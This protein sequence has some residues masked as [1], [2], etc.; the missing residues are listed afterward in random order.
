MNGYNQPQGNTGYPQQNYQQP[1]QYQQP[2]Q[3]QQG[4]MVQGE[5]QNPMEFTTGIYRGKIWSRTTNTGKQ[6]YKVMFSPEQAPDKQFSFK[7][8]DS[9]KGFDQMQ[10]GQLYKIG[11]VT[12]AP[13]TNRQGVTVTN[14]KTAMFFGIPDAAPIQQ[15]QM[16]Q[17]AYQ[18]PQ[19]TQNFQG[20][21]TSQQPIMQTPSS[22][23]L[24]QIVAQAKAEGKSKEETLGRY[25]LM[26]KASAPTVQQF[27]QIWG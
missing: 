17:Q 25:L 23:D 26:Y 24:G 6:Q 8:Y 12:D 13:F 1:V 4:Q 2:M 5:Q 7:A 14:S 27:T 11:F 9:T 15:P 3:P 21:N 10:E 16:Q 20:I 22:P 18:Q 19:P